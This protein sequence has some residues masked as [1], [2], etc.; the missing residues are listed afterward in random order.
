MDSGTGQDDGMAT[1]DDRIRF[2]AEV[3]LG[4]KTAT[5]IG[6]PDAVVEQLGS[7]NRPKVS[8]TIGSHTYRTTIARMGGRF[9]IP[10]AAEHREAAGVAAGETVEVRLTLDDAPREVEMPADLAM[11]LEAAG[12]RAAFDGL[13]YTHR[14]EHVRAI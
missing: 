2:A 12:V 13:S 1:K 7:G 4:G 5:G 14:K 8:V 11:A 10:L 6:V 9:M 3:E